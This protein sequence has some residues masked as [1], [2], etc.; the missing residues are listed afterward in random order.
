MKTASVPGPI[1]K[2]I[3]ASISEHNDIGSYLTAVDYE[4]SFG[5]YLVD[6][7]G[8]IMLD[9]VGQIGSL[10][11]GYN[12]PALY[13]KMASPEGIAASINRPNLGVLP[14]KDWDNRM[15][16]GLMSLAPP[17]LTNVVTMLC[18]S[19][20]NENAFKAATITYMRN[21]RA[22]APITEEELQSSVMNSEPG[23][24]KLSIMSFKGGF[25]GRTFGALAA[26][27]SKPD[28]KIDVPTFDWPIAPFPQCKFPLA[29]ENNR[30]EN[31]AEVSRCLQAVTELI[32]E[33]QAKSPVAAVVVEPI[34]GEGGDNHA[35]AEFFRGL[36]AITRE[37]GI[38][39]IVDEVQ[40]GGGPTGK[41]W[42]HEHWQLEHPPDIVTFAKK[43]QIA[44]YFHTDAF[45]PTM[46]FQ[47]FNTWMGDPAKMMQAE[48]LAEQMAEDQLLDVVKEAGE[49][50]L[51]G[52][53]RLAGAFPGDVLNVRGVGTFCAFT[54]SSPALRDALISHSRNRGLLISGC[55]PASIRFRPSLYFNEDHVTEA[56]TVLTEAMGAATAEQDGR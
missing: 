29:D 34:Q 55:G 39:M 49:A 48:V 10:P 2:E 44:G 26:T 17:G 54:L 46:P 27:H 6:A 35:P 4:S 19:T 22:G 45:K 31:M 20:S 50:L 9:C 16:D 3:V 37:H 42:A 5:N 12:H 36:R 23:C 43:L 8:N 33:Y 52:L 1:G 41:V 56:C 14:P 15:K 13:A 11:L 28:H 32:G 47:I 40:S 7:D 38:A 53:H 51:G 24:P 25:H 30:D 21:K 18:G